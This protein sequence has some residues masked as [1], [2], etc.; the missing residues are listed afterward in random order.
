MTEAEWLAAT[1]PQAMLTF[2][3]DT[4][5]TTD[6]KLRLFAAAC[7]RRVWHLLTD[8]R[9]RRGV[10]MA[11]GRAD[12]LVSGTEWLAGTHLI[13]RDVDA[14][15]DAYRAVAHAMDYRNF[16]LT[17]AAAV[18]A[19]YA[20][21]AISD[22]VAASE[23][24]DEVASEA[25][26]DAF[27]S[28]CEEQAALLRDIIGNPFRPPPPLAPSLRDYNG[29]LVLRLALSAYECRANPGG[30]LDQ[31]RLAVLADALLDAGCP[32]EAEILLHLRGEGLHWRGCWAVDLVLRKE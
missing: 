18:A 15:D 14:R 16:G 6:R 5:R 21:D 4:G 1:D 8:E 17:E 30:H 23:P 28:E 32:A 26:N 3:R 7:C 24:D 31:A 22:S 10:E 2:L 25:G 13:G 27:L 29:G 12:G 11:E 19:R 9:S 20:A